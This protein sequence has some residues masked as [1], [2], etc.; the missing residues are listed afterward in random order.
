M[1]HREFSP[2]PVNALANHP[3]IRPTIGGKGIL[4][5]TPILENPLNIAL[6][7]DHGGFVYVWCAPATYEVH[8]MVREEG[9]GKWALEAARL[10]LDSIFDMHGARHVWTRVSLAHPHV[11][12]FAVAAGMEACGTAKFDD[13]TGKQHSYA[14]YERRA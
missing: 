13:G 10:S 6:L 3:A 2:E 4:D 7:G 8:T 9:R 1:L 11:R 14:L 5:L 12:A